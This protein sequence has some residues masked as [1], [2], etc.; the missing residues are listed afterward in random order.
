MARYD[1]KRVVKES[2]LERA[3]ATAIEM[4]DARRMLIAAILSMQ[5]DTQFSED[6]LSD[7]KGNDRQAVYLF[8]HLL[9]GRR[10]K[11]K[12]SLRLTCP[13]FEMKNFCMSR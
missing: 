12:K 9:A 2:L 8:A 11:S 13:S 4:A 1:R 7:L 3:I 10:V 5:S 6:F